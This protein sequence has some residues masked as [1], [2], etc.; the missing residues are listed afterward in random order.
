MPEQTQNYDLIKQLPAEFYNR[1][2]DNQNLDLI[3]ALIK[4]L[5]DSKANGTDLT[6]LSNTLTQHL[7]ESSAKHI[8]SSGS[9]VNGSWIRFDD[10]T[11]MCWHAISGFGAQESNLNTYSWTYPIALS[12]RMSI[13]A[14]GFA[15]ME[16]Y[17]VLPYL[18]SL[19]L[20]SHISADI[21]VYLPSG[22]PNYSTVYLL[23]IGR[24]K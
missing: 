5:Q 6:S 14:T 7:D 17:P 4:A 8:H 20:P 1:E 3:D 18:R 24:W 19:S 15:N 2:L 9:N 12:T 13:Q 10:G 21:A 23:L 11:A 22:R 16:G